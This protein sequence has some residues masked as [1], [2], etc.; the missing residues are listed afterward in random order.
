MQH[1]FAKVP[2][3]GAK[4]G[5]DELFPELRLVIIGMPESALV[6]LELLDQLVY[7]VGRVHHLS[8]CIKAHSTTPT[9]HRQPRKYRPAQ[10][11][12]NTAP[13]YT[14]LYGESLPLPGLD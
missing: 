6:A 10:V 14:A 13:C 8:P 3:Q 2:S 12:R 4:E 1:L 5:I 7:A 9:T 11:S